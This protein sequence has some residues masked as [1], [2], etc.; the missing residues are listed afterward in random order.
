ML[1][2]GDRVLVAVSGG[3]DSMAMLHALFLLKD[4]LSFELGVVHLNHNLRGAE[5]RRDFQFVKDKAG[6]YGLPFFG[7]TLKAGILK[8]SS[9]EGL[10]AAARD[11]RLSFLNEMAKKFK[12]RR[13][14]MGHT[15]DD[16]AETLLMRFIKGSGLPGLSGMWPLRGLLIKPLIEITRAEAMAFIKAHDLNYIVDSSNLKD[17]YLRNNI[18]HH[19][20]PFIKER[21]NPSIVDS[22][23]R[24]ATMLR[25]DN[26]YIEAIATHLGVVIKETK[27]EVVLEAARLRDLHHSL[28]TRVFW[29]SANSFPIKSRISSAHIA[30]F[31]GLVNSEKPNLSI[32][33][34][35]GLT[36]RREYDRIIFTPQPLPEPR[37]FDTGVTVPGITKISGVGTL[38]A[39]LIDGPVDREKKGLA[40]FD[41][42]AIRLKLKARSFRPGDRIRPS[43]MKG[44][45]KVKD[46]FIDEKIPLHMRSRTPILYAGDDI[47]WIA[48]LRQSEACRA[49]KDTKKIVKIKFRKG[50]SIK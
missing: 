19:L 7:R 10:Q 25:H 27:N 17:S 16:Q 13:I 44:H 33:L 11:K 46:I 29:A 31:I 40:Y 36:V 37:P 28:L 12:A 4:E 2:P 24:T 8:K 9:S 26:N 34:P 49:G 20:L 50:R 32:T 48:G 14:A 47:L 39:E 21:Y 42:R 1:H 22:L 5:S 18:R 38:V 23:A 45:R 6:E 30:S 41:Y 43:G 3:P 35:G 15:M